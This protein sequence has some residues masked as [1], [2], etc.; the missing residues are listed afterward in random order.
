M[1]QHVSGLL[2]ALLT[3]S[4]PRGFKTAAKNPA[5]L[6]VI[7][8]ELNALRKN[9]TWDLVPRPSNTNIVG[10]KWV[11]RT[12]YQSDGSI[13]RLKARLVAK[14]YT[15]LPGLDYTDTF[16]PVVKASIVRVVLSLAI[17]HGWPIR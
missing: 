14:D 15:Q 6:A 13:D 1:S 17:T 9:Y 7:D 5:W 4:E 2:H 10:S 8:E 11:F 16:S 3:T 12:K